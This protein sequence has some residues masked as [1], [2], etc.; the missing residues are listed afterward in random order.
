MAKYQTG[1]F[2][3]INRAGFSNGKYANISVGA[4]AFYVWLKELEHCYTGG[5]NS[6]DFFYQ[7][8]KQIAEKMNV[9]TKSI[10][11]YRKE[12]IDAKLI[13]F[14]RRHWKYETG[15]RSEERIACYEII[16]EG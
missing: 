8:D 14:S 11:R 9:S 16:D 2:L 1:N 7:T 10:E 12:L 6:H 5:K 4:F 3:Q 15:K 13:K